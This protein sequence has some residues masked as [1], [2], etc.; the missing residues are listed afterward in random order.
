MGY[1]EIM[2][3]DIENIASTNQQFCR[4]IYEV[5]NDS[6]FKVVTLLPTP[7]LNQCQNN[8]NEPHNIPNEVRAAFFMA[9]ENGLCAQIVIIRRRESDDKKVKHKTKIYKF[10]EKSA[11][12]TLVRY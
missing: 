7:L 2:N 5:I 4:S 12:K 6:Y 8:P 1:Q 9:M 10:Q 3:L 11:K